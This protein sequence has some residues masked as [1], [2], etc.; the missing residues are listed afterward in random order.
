M[1]T[2]HYRS[3]ATEDSNATEKAGPFVM[4]L[5]WMLLP[6]LRE[7]RRREKPNFSDVILKISAGREMAIL[8]ERARAQDCQ[9]NQRG[10][11][12]DSRKSSAIRQMRR[13]GQ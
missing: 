10:F 7:V 8:A 4:L 2:M 5:A 12:A 13:Q 6:V 9:K 3:G 1:T 11:P